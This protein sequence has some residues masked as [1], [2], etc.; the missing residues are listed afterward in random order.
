MF[1]VDLQVP[2]E[3]NK[4]KSFFCSKQS[5]NTNGKGEKACAHMVPL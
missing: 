5:Y 4:K 1:V 2:R 3:R